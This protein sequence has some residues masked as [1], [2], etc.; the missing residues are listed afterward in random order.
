M[1]LK[2]Q[3]QEKMKARREE[4]RQKRQ[5][6]YDLDNEEGGFEEE[7][8]EMSEK[9]DTDVEDEEEN[10]AD[11]DEE[12]GEEEEGFEDM[13]G[14]DEEEEKEVMIRFNCCINHLTVSFLE[15]MT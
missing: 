12:E 2:E 1:A 6:L 9:S 8:A 15:W 10:E 11:I 3:L 7:E 4:A 5:E 14:E 13:Y